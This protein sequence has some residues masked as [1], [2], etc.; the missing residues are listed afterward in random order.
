MLSK[1]WIMSAMC[2]GAM[3]AP[4][5]NVAAITVPSEMQALSDYFQLLASKIQEGKHMA[6][7][8]VCDVSAAK[9]PVACKFSHNVN[10]NE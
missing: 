1:V 6:A 4:T 5:L 8:P 10:S 3:A 9:L 2:I 7:A